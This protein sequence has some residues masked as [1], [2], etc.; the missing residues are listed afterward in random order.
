MIT[1]QYQSGWQ[2]FFYIFATIS[3][4][5]DKKYKVRIINRKNNT[6]VTLYYFFL[7]QNKI[8]HLD[9]SWKQM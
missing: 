4:L 3:N 6:G 7:S 8:F 9:F 2:E 1:L 5:V